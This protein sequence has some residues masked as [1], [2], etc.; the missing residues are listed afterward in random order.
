MFVYLDDVD[1]HHACADAAGAEIEHPPH[2]EDYGLTYT[3]RDLNGYPWSY[4]TAPHKS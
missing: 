2:D 3:A 1:A 4:T